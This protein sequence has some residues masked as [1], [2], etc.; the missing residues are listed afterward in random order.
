MLRAVKTLVKDQDVIGSIKALALTGIITRTANT[1]APRELIQSTPV[2]NEFVTKKPR[3]IGSST[4][5]TFDH[6]DST[7]GYGY[8]KYTPYKYRNNNG[9]YSYYENVYKDWFNKYGRMRQPTVDPY[10]LVK[11]IQWK[12][13]VRSR[14]RGNILR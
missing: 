10:S 9:R 14:Q 6:Y 7:K 8:E 13:Y 3:S 2:L 11:S 4:A 5:F 1:F 12:A